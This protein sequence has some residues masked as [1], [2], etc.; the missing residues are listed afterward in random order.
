M[1]ALD[2]KLEDPAD[3]SEPIPGWAREVCADMR[4]NAIANHRTL[5]EEMEPRTANEE[6]RQAK[7]GVHLTVEPRTVKEEAR[8]A[9]E[10]AERS[11]DSNA[12]ECVADADEVWFRG[13]YLVHG[14]L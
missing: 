8:Q 4:A 12:Q 5:K 10:E 3:S 7:E 14:H 9:T 6:A 1:T 13:S 2:A 11:A